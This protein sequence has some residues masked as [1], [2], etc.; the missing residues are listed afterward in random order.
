VLG[1]GRRRHIPP[2]AVPGT[3]SFPPDHEPF[4]PASTVEHAEGLVDDA[5]RDIDEATAADE[6]IADEIRQ[7]EQRREWSRP[8]LDDALSEV[9][10][11][12]PEVAALCA[13]IETTRQQ[14]Y[15]FSWIASAIGRRRLP[16]NFWDGI[17][18]GSDRGAA[19]QWR[20]A[21]ARLETDPD[22]VLPSGE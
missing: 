16:P 21:I 4:D 7:V 13:R 6:L 17:L 8:G 5:R 1:P 20:A 19:D 22:A 18:W 14:L 3:R 11:A 12:S 2:V 10:R 15:D 9:L